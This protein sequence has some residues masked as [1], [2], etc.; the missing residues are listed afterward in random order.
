MDPISLVFY[1]VV[2]G[3]LSLFAP[4]L[5]G[6][7]PRLLIGAGVGVLAAFALPMIRGVIGG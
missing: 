6:Y 2:C 5:G 4:N 1:A 3:L 7:L